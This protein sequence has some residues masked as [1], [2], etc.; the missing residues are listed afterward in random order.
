MGQTHIQ[1][2]QNTTIHHL[3]MLKYISH[4]DQCQ[5]FNVNLHNVN[6]KKYVKNVFYYYCMLSYITLSMRTFM[7]LSIETYRTTIYIDLYEL[8]KSKEEILK[9]SH[10]QIDQTTRVLNAFLNQIEQKSK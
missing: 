2:L 10:L 4:S 1:T 7:T 3:I 5:E 9:D 8:K 6:T